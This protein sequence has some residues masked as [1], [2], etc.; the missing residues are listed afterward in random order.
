MS[1]E[2]V[3]GVWTCIGIAW[4]VVAF[5][6]VMSVR[7]RRHCA[8]KPD[9]RR[10]TVFK[11]L[12]RSLGEEEFAR[13]DKPI[14][15]FIADLDENSEL[16]IGCH[17]PDQA[18]LEDYVRRMRERHP[19]ADVRLVVHENPNRYPHPKVSWMCVLAPYATGELW[20]WSDS[21]M[22]APPG[23]IRSMRVDYERTKARCLTSPYVVRQTRTSAEMLDTLY[24]NLEF[25][26]GVI[27]LSGQNMIQFGLGSGMLFEAED[28][29]RRVDWDF[30]GGCLAEDFHLGGLL[31]PTQLGSM[32]L[33]T[34]PAARGWKEAF[35]HYLRWQKN[36]RWCRPLPY[37]AQLIIHS[38]ARLA[39][40]VAH[41]PARTS[42]LV[43]AVGRVGRRFHRR[44]VD[45]PGGGLLDRLEKT[46]H[47]SA[48][49]PAPGALL[50]RL[51]VPVAHRLAGT[52]VVVPPPGCQTPNRSA[53]GPA[54][55]RVRIEDV[56]TW[57]SSLP[58]GLAGSN[59]FWS[60]FVC[61][62]RGPSAALESSLS[63][64]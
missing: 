10:I 26:P 57:P 30:L 44:P 18:R 53:G 51:L 40:L 61:R 15:S 35:L 39:G 64:R 50:V 1:W 20:L 14:E 63:L 45:L 29:K 33:S 12:P 7:N 59:R 31:K 62:W 36:V 60:S 54:R 8:G 3:L 37:A 19:D 55:T 5:V 21:D 17:R 43:W 9:P 28:F 4:W 25:Y 52:E 22:R 41:Q 24:V 42:R 11:P 13:F 34:V 46:P 48:L 56:T 2:W 58:S 32:C 16:L 6:L 23:T 38:V 47:H 49:E 27:L